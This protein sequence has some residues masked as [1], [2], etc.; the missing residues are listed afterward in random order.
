[1]DNRKQGTAMI[2]IALGIM[3]ISL[4]AKGAKKP[5][6]VII[7]VDPDV[8]TPT[9]PDAG[10]PITPPENTFYSIDLG[11]IEVL[12]VNGLKFIEVGN[13][14]GIPYGRLE[15]QISSNKLA[16]ATIYI[17]SKITLASDAIVGFYAHVRYNIDGNIG[18]PAYQGGVFPALTCPRG[19]TC[20]NPTSPR[21][22]APF[23]TPIIVNSIWGYGGWK[24]L[25]YSA[26]FD[27]GAMAWDIGP[28]Y[29][30]GQFIVP[31]MVKVTESGAITQP[32]D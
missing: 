21:K 24:P 27:I 19:T 30:L 32:Q 11:R 9:N 15:K 12:G 1:M 5:S 6:P 28:Y 22:D 4:I 20:P 8:G 10:E 7:P 29:T 25:E 14:G 17:R 13:Y 16:G 18:T 26:L 3:G 31:N 23:D 2:G